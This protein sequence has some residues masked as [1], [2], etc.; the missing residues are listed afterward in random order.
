ML[1]AISD[2]I[3]ASRAIGSDANA[4]MAGDAA[5]PENSATVT[6]PAANSMATEGAAETIHRDVRNVGFIRRRSPC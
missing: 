5:D 2:G 4:E 6:R 3:K 1:V